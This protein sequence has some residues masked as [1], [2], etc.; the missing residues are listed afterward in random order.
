M[1][2]WAEQQQWNR[3]KSS[4]LSATSN[5]VS[6]FKWFA[7]SCHTQETAKLHSSGGRLPS[8]G[9]RPHRPLQPSQHLV[10]SPGPFGAEAASDLRIRQNDVRSSF[11]PCT[12]T[13]GQLCV[14]LRLPQPKVLSHWRPAQRA[15]AAPCL[16]RW[17]RP[18]S[19]RSHS[20][21]Q[22]QHPGR[23]GSWRKQGTSHS[24]NKTDWVLGVGRQSRFVLRF[25]FRK[26][27]RCKNV[28]DS[29][30]SLTC[31]LEMTSTRVCW[32]MDWCQRPVSNCMPLT[33]KKVFGPTRQT[34]LQKETF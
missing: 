3:P 13:A 28:S 8:L 1:C 12:R 31:V 6:M 24:I 22:G 26:G 16:R 23:E 5:K 14:R 27:Q 32:E 10:H 17:G 25:S 21:A 15:A 19:L 30:A 7:T 4:D 29:A 18:A 33:G 2:P 9:R 34:D 20:P 11:L